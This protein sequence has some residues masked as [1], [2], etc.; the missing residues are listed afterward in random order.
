MATRTR[1]NIQRRRNRRPEATSRGTEQPPFVPQT[2]T[3]LKRL[4]F[5][6]SGPND[7]SG[8]SITNTD[9]MDLYCMA[10]TTTTAY[11]IFNAVRIVAVEVWVPSALDTTNNG[12]VI[13]SCFLEFPAMVLST[14][15]GGRSVRLVDTSCSLDHSAHVRAN[16]PEGSYAAMWQTNTAIAGTNA[17]FNI[18]AASTGCIVDLT[19]ELAIRDSALAPQPVTAAVVGATVGQIYVRPLSSTTSSALAP[20]G[21]NTI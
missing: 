20:V 7:P 2:M 12:M 17:L 6:S 16:P 4:R 21:V 3:V 11:Q 18:G 10:V 1:R 19:I 5:V 9:L 14:G 13:N 15:L 8:Y